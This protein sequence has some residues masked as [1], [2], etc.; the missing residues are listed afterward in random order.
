[1][2]ISG[3][4]LM[5]KRDF[6]MGIHAPGDTY[7]IALYTKDADVS[8]ST[9][10][11]TPNGEVIAQGYERGGKVLQGYQCGLDGTTAVLGWREPVTWPDA[12][13]TAWGALIYNA[14]KGGRAIVVVGFGKGVSSTND[15]FKLLPPPCQAETALIRIL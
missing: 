8:P 9:Q 7:K 5:A 14:S 15:M 2:I 11:Y 10:A 3:M 12:T 4:C 13:M 6:L 1:M